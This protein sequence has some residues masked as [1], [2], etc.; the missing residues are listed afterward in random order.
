MTHLVTGAA[1]FIGSSLVDRLLA[2]GHRVIGVDNFSTGQRRFLDGALAHPGFRLVEGDL[3]D[4]TLLAPHL[5]GI[6]VV[7]HLAANADIRS[8]LAQPRRDLA[9]NTVVTLNVLEAMRHAHARRI[10][11]ASSAAALGEPTVFPTP[12]TCETPIQTSLYGASK[13]ACEG[14]ISAYCQGY[15]FEGHVFR[16]VSLLGPRYPH[17]HVFDFV[18]QLLSDPGRLTVLGDGSPRKSYLHIADCLDALLHIGEDRRPARASRQRFEVYHLG[19]PAYCRVRDSV[20]WICSE[21]GLTPRIEFGSGERGWI[22]D[23]PF[24]FL[25]VG[26]AIS[27]GWQPRHDIEPAVRETARWLIDNRWIFEGER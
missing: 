10:V 27:T 20:G 9:Q 16:F 23:N 13:M 1:G 7:Y 24:V 26:K 22:G 12:E 3:L 2:S 21:L 15:G 18:R 6:D 8:G 17:G 4:E 11:F 14:L 5:A 19:Y 25:D